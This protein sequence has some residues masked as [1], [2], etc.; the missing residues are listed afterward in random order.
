MTTQYLISEGNQKFY[1]DIP[2]EIDFDKDA[3]LEYTT[4][5]GKEKEW[6]KI[7]AYTF[8]S[9]NGL[10]RINGKMFYGKV[11]YL[12]TNEVFRLDRQ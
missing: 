5:R 9:W 6:R 7:D 2:L 3:D 4:S 8:R 1:P 12:G 11:Y 10:R